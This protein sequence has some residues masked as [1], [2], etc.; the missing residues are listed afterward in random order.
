[1]WKWRTTEP[2]SETDDDLDDVV[3]DVVGDV[4][5]DVVDDVDDDVVDDV[6][7]DVV[8]DV[9]D[10]DAQAI[11]HQLFYGLSSSVPP[12]TEYLPAK[13]C[14]DDGHHYHYLGLPANSYQSYSHT[15]FH[16]SL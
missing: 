16:I 4:V 3:D 9:D 7:Y 11:Q 14:D 1:M 10:N 6:D 15:G 2:Y 13:V 5:D 12:P 8:Y